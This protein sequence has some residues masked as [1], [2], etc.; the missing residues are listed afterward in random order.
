MSANDL[1]LIRQLVSQRR[2]ELAPE[3]SEKNTSI[4]L[5]LS[6]LL[7]ISDLSYDEIQDG[8]VNGGG[9]GGIDAIYLFINNTLCRDN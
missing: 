5:Q 3:L 8:I 4:S 9:D 7:K 6:R 1:I 2:S